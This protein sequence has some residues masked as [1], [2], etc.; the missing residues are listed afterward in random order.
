[1]NSKNKNELETPDIT[2]DTN[3]TSL[4]NE[5]E[6]TGKIWRNKK[7]SLDE[8]IQKSS[9]IHKNK[10]DYSKINYINNHTKVEIICPDHGSFWQTPCNH[11]NKRDVDYVLII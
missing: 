4:K 3:L 11:F 7:L 10:Y 1:M 8:F 6:D 2:T 9:K 5:C